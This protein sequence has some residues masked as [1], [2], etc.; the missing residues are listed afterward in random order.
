VS[1][2][3]AEF[4]LRYA[5]AVQARITLAVLTELRPQAEDYAELASDAVLDRPSVLMGQALTEDIER[6]TQP[7]PLPGTRLPEVTIIPQDPDEEL[8]RV[9]PAFR[10]SEVEARLQ[11]LAY[12]PSHSAL[13][14][15]IARGG[16]DLVV[17]GAENRA[18]QHRMFFGYENQRVIER[19]AVTTLI[20]VPK[21]GRLK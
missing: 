4:A 3:A 2:V 9:S 5:E 7:P 18:V 12:D 16:Y 14:E 10:A 6:R 15:E 21:M 13:T 17:T 1:R 8:A 19:S 11:Y 20:V